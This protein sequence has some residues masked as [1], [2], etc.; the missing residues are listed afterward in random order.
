V[1]IAYFMEATSHAQAGPYDLSLVEGSISTPEQLDQIKE[2]RR[3]STLLVA[4]GACATSGGIQALRQFADIEAYKSTVYAS[5]KHIKT[6]SSSSPVSD[7]VSVDFELQG[8]PISKEQL[9]EVLASFLNGKKPNI[10]NFSVCVECKIKGTVC[11]PVS[12][13]RACLGPVTQAGC[14]ALCPSYQRGCFGCFGPKELSQPEALT[15][16]V[17]RHQQAGDLEWLHLLRNYQTGA[18][19]FKEEGIRHEKENLKKS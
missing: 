4:I 11:L 7:H 19:E 8:C 9:I 18:A 13:G 12:Q 6:L 3:E 10:P 17:R 14:G 5:P 16:F 15:R 2:I 1:E